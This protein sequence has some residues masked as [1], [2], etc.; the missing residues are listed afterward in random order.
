MNVIT[1]AV[2]IFVVSLAATFAPIRLGSRV[3]ASRLSDLTGIASGLLLASALVVVI[4]EGFHTAAEAS[5]GEAFAYDPVVL[6]AMIL[7]G[8][9]AIMLLEGLG[10]G[11]AVHEE[12]HDHVAGHGHG[13][14][15]HPTSA[16]VLAL[17]LSLHSVADGI[18]IGAAAAA[19]DEAVSAV[20]A[21]GVL[22]HRIPAAAS[23]GLFSLH[24]NDVRAG[25][26]GGLIWFAIATPAALLVS[27]GLLEGADG[28]AVAL[29]LLFSAGTFLY[30][31]TV[32]TLPAVHNPAT[33]RRSARNVVLSA[34]VFTLILFVLTA[35]D[36]LGSSH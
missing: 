19:G 17:G 20:V 4:P 15:H 8:F 11:H 16:K 5:D 35:T 18:A 29:A 26:V 27:Y 24:D 14:V 30:V 2:V 3:N 32:D 28:G 13:H 10:I 23:L 22:V 7:A 36:V 31:A 9:L 12:H 25:S 1:I 33:G 21:L 34:G 6:G